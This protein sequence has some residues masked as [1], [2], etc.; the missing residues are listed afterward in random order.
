M[1][2]NFT[3]LM[4]SSHRLDAVKPSPLALPG[5]RFAA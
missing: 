3:G 5:L 2:V 4:Q 1:D